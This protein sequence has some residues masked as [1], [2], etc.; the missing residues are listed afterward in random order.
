MVSSFEVQVQE[1]NGSFRTFRKLRS[2]NANAAIQESDKL[3]IPFKSFPKQ[4]K[5]IIELQNGRFNV[6]LKINPLTESE[7][8]RKSILGESPL[9]K[10]VRRFTR[11]KNKSTGI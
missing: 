1:E 2:R 3:D 9:G 8:S 5:R 7:R 10:A 4:R 6:V 11:N